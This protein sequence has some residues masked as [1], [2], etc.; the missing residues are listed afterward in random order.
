MRAPGP[1]RLAC[2]GLAARDGSF[3][4]VS[5]QVHAGE[6]LGLYGLI[7]AGRTEWGQ[8]VFGLRDIKRGESLHVDDRRVAPRG[9]ASMISLGVGYLPEDR[10]RQGLCRGL[11]VRAN[12][13]LAILRRLARFTWVSLSE[14]TRRTRATINQLA[15]KAHAPNN[16]RARSLAAISKRSCWA[17]G[18]AAIRRS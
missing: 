16:S 10:L 12:T 2:R 14:E 17:A 11:S 7:G 6:I 8:A 15:I 1:V 4:D 5:L 18:W 9:P 3:H 13:V